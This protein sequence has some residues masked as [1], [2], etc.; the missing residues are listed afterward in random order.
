LGITNGNT[1][2]IGSLTFIDF[3]H[4]Q[5]NDNTDTLN[6]TL[7]GTEVGGIT[8]DGGLNNDTVNLDGGNAGYAGVYTPD[9]LVGHDQLAYTN[10]GNTYTVNYQNTESIQDNLIA[11]SLTVN[12][13]ALD[14]SISLGTDDTPTF[15]VNI[16]P[17]VNFENKQTLIVNGLAGTDVV[18]T[19]G[20]FDLGSGNL[21]LI[22]ETI[23]NTANALITANAFILDGVSSAGAGNRLLTNVTDLGLTGVSGAV[24]ISEQDQINI[25]QLDTTGPFDLSADQTISSAGLNTSADLTLASSNG[26]ILLDNAANTLGGSLALTAANGTVNVRNNTTTSI[27]TI[28]AQDLTI[29]STGAISQTGGITV[30]G[31]TGLSSSADITLTGANNFNTLGVTSANN[32]SI[33]DTNALEITG[34]NA[35][36]AVAVNSSGLALGSISAASASLDAGS[37]AITDTN[38]NASNIAAGQIQLRASSGIGSG[39]ALETQ[40]AN[41]DVINST[42]G[43]VEITN[44]GQVTLTNL[45]NNGDIT[46]RN[47]QTVTIDNVDA[48]YTVGRFEIDVASGSIYGVPRAPADYLVVPDITADSAFITVPDEFGTYDRPIVMLINSD[49]F[50]EANVSSPHYLGDGPDSI[51][52]NSVITASVVDAIGSASQQRLIEVESIEDIDPAIFTAVRNYNYDDISIRMPRDQLYED[53]LDRLGQ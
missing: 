51:I 43:N 14:D 20:T 38:G 30:S 31:A 50:L 36:G 1:G 34:I 22:A 40:T 35:S 23:N 25:S 2:T 47:D 16:N 9:A 26:D 8:F 46:F 12:G 53:E 52:N 44:N 45:V 6:I 4:I 37:G 18:D 32:V 11:N 13:T 21:H 24:R 33:N 28:S 5:G 15:R 48:G 41:L 10:A 42:S 39:N 29:N 17:L 3:T 49:L 27:N 7:T 19:L